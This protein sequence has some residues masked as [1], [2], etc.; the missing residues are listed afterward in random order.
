M[1]RS[2]LARLGGVVA[3][4]AGLLLP[5]TGVADEI[6][7]LLPGDKAFGL[8]LTEWATAYFQWSYS[9]PASGHPDSDTT[10]VQ[11]G[12]G[13]RMPVWFLPNEDKFKDSTRTIVIPAGYEILFSGPYNLYLRPPGETTDEELLAELQH[14]AEEF[15][16]QLT[17][18]ELS[19]DGVPIPNLRQYRVRTPIFSVVLPPANRLN[20]SITA[21]KDPRA[22]GIGEGYFLLLTSLPVGKHVLRSNVQ[23]VN[24]G[25]GPFKLTFVH[26][27]VIQEPNT[28]I[29]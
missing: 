8:T 6:K 1:H 19:I 27:L 25:V 4:L 15:L 2:C 5:G 29:Q 18:F 12:R 11:A 9:L 13:Q 21:G 22:A 17:R 7:P 28:P 24:P 16:D 20:F 23:G 10:G 14:G 3:V 26:N